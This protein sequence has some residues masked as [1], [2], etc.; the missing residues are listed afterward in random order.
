[1]QRPWVL[2]EFSI[3]MAMNDIRRAIVGWIFDRGALTITERWCCNEQCTIG[4]NYC[5]EHL[6]ER[7]KEDRAR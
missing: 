1:M 2:E 5:P 6:A 4:F 3:W 7:M